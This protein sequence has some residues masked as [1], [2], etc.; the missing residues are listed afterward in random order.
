MKIFVKSSSK[1]KDLQIKNCFQIPN[2]QH[3]LPL[4][5]LLSEHKALRRKAALICSFSIL[6]C[7]ALS[8]T[9]KPSYLTMYSND[10]G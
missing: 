1:I 7:M 10:G 9:P 6:L 4:T 5:A 8:S 2:D 3:F